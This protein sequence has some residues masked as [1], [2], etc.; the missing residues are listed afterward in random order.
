MH[1]GQLCVLWDDLAI[2]LHVGKDLPLANWRCFPIHQVPVKDANGELLEGEPAQ[3]GERLTFSSKWKYPFFL[4]KGREEE[5][6][7]L[8]GVQSLSVVLFIYF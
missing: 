8:K 3:P 5:E 2:R 1:E 6:D 4:Q 7:Y